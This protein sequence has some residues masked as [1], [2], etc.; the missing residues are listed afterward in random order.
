MAYQNKL[1]FGINKF[2][3]WPETRNELSDVVLIIGLEL[4][5]DRVFQSKRVWFWNDKIAL[6]KLIKYT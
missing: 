1:P 6:K 4:S 2:D 5:P 3:L